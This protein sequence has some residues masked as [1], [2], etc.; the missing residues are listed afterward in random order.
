[1]ENNDIKLK[2][3]F[4]RIREERNLGYVLHAL[5]RFIDVHTG[6]ALD[7]DLGNIERDYRL[8]LDFMKRGY[9]DP[10]RENVYNNLYD[11]LYRFALNLNR[12]YLIKENAFFAEVYRKLANKSFSCERIRMA[13]EGFVAD[14]AMLSLEAEEVREVKAKEIYRQHSS[15]MQSLFCYIVVSQQWTDDEARFFMDLLLSP[16]VDTNDAQMIVSATMLAAMHNSDLNKLRTLLNTYQKSTDEKVRQKALVGWVFA[17]PAEEMS[18]PEEKEMVNEALKSDNM[19]SELTDLQKQIVFCMNAEKDRETIQK[20]IMP[21]IIKHNNLNITRFGI[22][23][24]EEDPMTDVFDPG[25]TDRAMEKLEDSFQKMISMQKAGSDIYFGGFSQMKRFPFFYNLSNWFCPFYIEHPDI[26]KAADKLK[27]TPMLMTILNNG[28]FC[29]SDKYSFTLALSSV[30]SHLPADMREMFNSKDVLGN[31]VSIE[32]AKKPAYIRRMILQDLYRFFRLYPQKEQLVNPFSKE[33][34]TFVANDVF[35]ETP[36]KKSYTEL[37]YFMLKHK[38]KAALDKIMPE[39]IIEGD[40]KCMLFQ[41]IYKLDYLHNLTQAMLYLE[42]LLKIE[43]DNKRGLMLLAR[44]YFE[45]YEYE[46]AA[47]CYKH[48]TEIAPDNKTAALNYCIALVKCENYEKAIK[49]LYKLDFESPDTPSIMRVLAWTQMGFGKIEQAEATYKRLLSGNDIE[50]GDWLNAGYCQWLIGKTA[51]AVSMFQKF[52]KQSCE[53]GNKDA[54]FNA[55]TDEDYD[56][57]VDSGFSDTE[58]NLM[59]DIV[60]SNL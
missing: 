56:F 55:L 27:G 44:V 19:V 32:D 53:T 33:R 7:D 57:L 6:L 29:D 16:T 17:L 50:T 43:P 37:V 60:Q 31:S 48:V 26:E 23:E 49:P 12:A 2:D 59:L 11:R 40:A 34:F 20:D 41:G 21:E 22:T 58:I 5:H 3:I 25:A 42:Q 46:A 10:E 28:P 30:I 45:E 18:L 9:D 52:Y 4:R 51:E 39:Y 8:M 38:N 47:E 13:L 24:K 1:M 14:I 35:L 36:M 54:F 15:F